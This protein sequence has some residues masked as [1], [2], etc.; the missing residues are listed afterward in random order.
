MTALTLGW[1]FVA[2]DY[3]RRAAA[4]DPISEY[5]LEGLRTGAPVTLYHGTTRLFRTFDLSHGRDEL[6]DQFYGKG[7]FLTPSKRVA[8]KYAEANRNIGFPPSI[9]DDLKRQNPAAGKFLQALFDHGQD[10]WEVAW[11]EEGFWRDNPAPG[12]GVVD[13]AAF[14]AH[15]GTDS[16]TLQD[17]AD[18]IL[19][20]KS[21]PLGAGDGPIDLFGRGATGLPGYLY[22]SLDEVGL[23]S[24]TY[25]PKVYTV[26]VTTT[27][28]LVTK[29]QSAARKA[30]E[31][32]Y[33]CVVY[34][35]TALVS[36]VPEVAVFNPRQVRIRKIEVV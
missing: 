10:G 33:D 29:S 26:S 18:Y 17:I 1:G 13:L 9:I 30:R 31:K 21:K 24:K 12:E 2:Y 20:S 16:N 14:D 35:G 8:E 11:K 27:N 4:S 25:R 36:G 19:G 7:I 6:V 5:G 34:H 15:L 32:G 3:D 23:D 22:D 28:P